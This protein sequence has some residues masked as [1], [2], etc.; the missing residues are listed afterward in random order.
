[1][2][3]FTRK[4]K[5]GEK[6]VNT[7]VLSKIDAMNGVFGLGTCAAGVTI[8]PTRAL[9]V[10]TIL[11]C[12]RLISEDV[13]Q[14]PLGIYRERENGGKTPARDHPAWRVLARRP[15]DWM[16]SFEWRQTMLAHCVLTGNA[17]SFI[18]RNGRGEVTELL[19][20]MPGQV[21]VQQRPDYELVYYLSDA[22]SGRVGVYT[23][24]NIFH[25]RG[26]AWLTYRGLD[27][28]AQA[29]HATGLAV[30]AED[31]QALLHKNGGQQTGVL[32]SP[33]RLNAEQ[34]ERIREQSRKA[35]TGENLHKTMVLD[36]GMTFVPTL[37]KGVD[38]Q[39]IE[40][41]KHQVE[42][43]CRA[44]RVFPQMVMHTD[45]T[46]TFA[47]AAE[48]SRMHV[49]HTLG[50]WIERLQ[51]AIDRDLLDRDGTLFARLD[52]DGLLRGSPK[53]RS[54]L[55]KAGVLDGWMTRNE[56][57]IKEGLDPLP[58]LDEPIMPLNMTEV[59][60]DNDVENDDEEPRL[61]DQGDGG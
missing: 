23:R 25:L 46:A 48:F 27:M 33:E 21:S 13:A 44:F 60:E 50:P 54:A 2:W 29:R 39:H 57:R 8:T 15:N 31:S 42:E 1:M 38:S 32:T 45:K 58:G 40:T 12:V 9:Q 52:T 18:N 28:V 43:I 19:P 16:T 41:R 49:V 5:T 17:Y 36:G 4:P 37:M 22:N 3:P 20:L 47:S 7:G 59:R 30:A 51:Q 14:L 56:V 10:A 34:I 61:V 11:S 26:P 55:Y 53:E 24:E 35:Q 6:A